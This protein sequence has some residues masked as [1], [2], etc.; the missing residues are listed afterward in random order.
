MENMIEFRNVRKAFGNLQ[1]LNGTNLRIQKGE[2]V[3]VLGTS[4]TG[5]S[6]LLK[7]IVGL[8]KTDSGEIFVDGKD[9]SRFSEEELF[10]VRKDCGM[11]FQQP[12]LFDSITIFE[13]VA[14]GLRR[15]LKLSEAEIKER[16]QKALAMVYLSGVENKFPSQIS[17]G[18]QKRASLA[19]TVVLQPKILMFDEPTTGLDPVTTGAINRLIKELSK[20][21][22]T[23]SIVVS[24]DMKCALEIAD[25]ILLLE[26]G[27]IVA[28]GTPAELK[29]S[30]HPLVMEF[31][32]EIKE[33]EA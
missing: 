10:P 14:Y 13:N 2:I 11:V 26:K 17:Y 3:F 15:H 8:L 32:A 7:T 23:T 16:V 27:E 6:V 24:H 20:K 30:K 12:A 5:K 1:V 25:R 29:N 33:G 22:K 18:M 9:V 21:L 28:Q 19:R 4:G 31:L